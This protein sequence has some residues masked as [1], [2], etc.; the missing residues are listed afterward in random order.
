MTAGSGL[1]QYHNPVAVTF[2]AGALDRLP[3]IVGA[4]KAVLITFPEAG[5][6]G[7]IDRVRSLLGDAISG[8]IDATQANPDVAQL[9][10]LYAA[11]WQRY[12]DCAAVI[13]LG[14]GSTLDT[15]KALMIGTHSGTI[16]EM[17]QALAAGS[18]FTPARAK[19]LIA[20]PTTAGTGSEVTPFAT[21]WDAAP[22]R[23]KKYSLQLPQTWAE[24]AVVDPE[25]ALSLPEPVTLHS[26]LDALSHSL[27]AIWNVN[28]NPVSDALAVE[29]AREVLA[30]LP[31]LMRAPSDLGLRT[32]VA[33]AALTAGLAFSNTRTALAHSI[34]YEMTLR[35]GLPHGLA[36]SF[37][38]PLVFSRAIGRSR[39]RDAVLARIFDRCPLAEAPA[40]LDTFLQALGVDT[41]FECYGVAPADAERMVNSALDGVRGRNFIGAPAAEIAT[42]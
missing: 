17:L 37:T 40:F 12:G 24:A 11:F 8:V 25:L 36:C 21:I 27:E 28:S 23:Q 15:A 2:G 9:K 38:L 13:G 32:R 7:L 4:R 18:A 42:L 5:A 30:V 22:D 26:A 31:A 39:S 20:I 29:A 19:R 14:G 6:L 34:S 41:G 10:D 35:H 1:W 3:H 16:D 33:R